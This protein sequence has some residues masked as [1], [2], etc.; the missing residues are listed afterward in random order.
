MSRDTV[1]CLLGAF[2]WPEF[3]LVR[4]RGGRLLAL[5]VSVVGRGRGYKEVL[6]LLVL[7]YLCNVYLP[8]LRTGRSVTSP[9]RANGACAVGKIMLSFGGRPVVNTDIFVPKADVKMTASLSKGCMLGMPTGAGGVRF[10]C[11]K[12]RGGIIPFGPGSLGIFHIIAVGRSDNVTLRSIAVMT[13]TGRGG[14]SM[15]NSI[16]AVGPTRLGAADDGLAAKFTK[17]L[18]K[19]ITCREDKRPNRSGTRFFVHNIAAFKA[20][21]TSPLVLVSGVRLASSSLTELG[22]SS[23][24]DFSVLGSTATATLCNTHNTGNIVLMA[25]G[26]NARNGVGLSFE[27]RDSFSTPSGRIRVTSPLAFVGLR[28]RTIEA[29]GPSNTLPCL[30]DTVTTH[31]GKLGPV[32]CPVMS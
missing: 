22:A 12:C 18:T 14:R 4:G 19:M 24:T 3:V 5:L 32:T 8:P 10:S 29:Q 25:A 11:V 21:G 13:F 2:G 7:F 16:S 9:R 17:G 6:Q 30:R 31:R 28:G 23:V 15:L 26:R 20:K 27:M 1:L